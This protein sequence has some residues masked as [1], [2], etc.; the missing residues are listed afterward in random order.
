MRTK[1]DASYKDGRAYTLTLPSPGEPLNPMSVDSQGSQRA[2]PAL[3]LE[4]CSTGPREP[5]RIP[6]LIPVL[7]KDGT[8]LFGKEVLKG[9]A[10][11][12]APPQG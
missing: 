6:A 12:P 9:F 11:A 1:C 2:K 10:L 7:H 3:P 4:G 8:S 5:G